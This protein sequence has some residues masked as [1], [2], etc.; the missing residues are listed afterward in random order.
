MFSSLF[1]KN[2]KTSSA[3][4]LFLSKF[5]SPG[6]VGNYLEEQWT[7]VLHEK[8]SEV[9]KRFLRDGVLIE[10]DIADCIDFKY[11]VTDLKQMLLKYG[12]KQS[13]RKKELILRLLQQDHAGMKKAIAG[14]KVYRCS[15]SCI[16]ITDMYLA[17]EKEK[18]IAVEKEVLDLLRMRQFQQASGVV[19]RYESEQVFPRGLGIDWINYNTKRDENILHSIFE[20]NPKF[21]AKL[22][23]SKR[24]PLRILAGMI[25][26][27]GVN[28]GGSGWIDENFDT[29][30]HLDAD[31][32]ARM[33]MFHA[34]SLEE[35][36]SY[37]G[38]AKKVR[39]TSG[40]ND[41]L[42]CDECKK[43]NGKS[44]DINKVPELP[45]E[46]CISEMGCRCWYS[47]EF[48]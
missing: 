42:V 19:A 8:P 29:S 40:V 46:K 3:H 7:P 28:R 44:F 16:Q 1:I 26:L 2:W 6:E 37:R 48:S 38:M 9:I 43:M 5:R 17:K 36:K 32:A 45:Y 30:I 39:I 21:L 11:K 41:N 22:Y 31:A 13:G 20:K 15:T 23:S 33:Y 25:H 4:L 24:E 12:L 35:L 14:L 27:W 10:G 34:V 18:H 47:P